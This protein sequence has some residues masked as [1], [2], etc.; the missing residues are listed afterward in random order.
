MWKRR[1]EKC[2][3]NINILPFLP[4]TIFS[5]LNIDHFLILKM[6]YKMWYVST[7]LLFFLCDM[8][9]LCIGKNFNTKL[10]I[11]ST[12]LISVEFI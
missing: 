2:E 1:K 12:V 10:C 11:L 6:I 9:K 3:E 5:S 7:W 4:L 8:Y